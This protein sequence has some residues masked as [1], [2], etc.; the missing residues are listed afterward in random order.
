VAS[1]ERRVALE[2][3]DVRGIVADETR[4]HGIGHARRVADDFHELE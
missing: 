3:A 1:L 2:A 4:R